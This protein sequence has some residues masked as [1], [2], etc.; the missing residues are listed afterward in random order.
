MKYGDGAL[1]GKSGIEKHVEDL[2][3][4]LES[5]AQFIS[6]MIVS[7]F[8]QLS[9][10]G[11]VKYN[12]SQFSKEFN[13]EQPKPEIIFILANHTPRGKKLL[14][15]LDRLQP[16]L[17]GLNKHSAFGIRFFVA[18]SAGYALHEACMLTLDEYRSS[19]E[20]SLAPICVD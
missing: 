17:E 3:T 11:L 7:Q 14:N 1:D 20:P 18:S 12:E 9:A 19:P 4:I 8:K 10:L 16:R 5:K 6:E 2:A 15:V 13:I